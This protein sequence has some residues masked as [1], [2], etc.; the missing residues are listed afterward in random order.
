MVPL[1]SFKITLGLNAALKCICLK[2]TCP[3]PGSA[4]VPMSHSSHGGGWLIASDRPMFSTSEPIQDGAVI[5]RS[6][7]DLRD[8]AEM[9]PTETEGKK[10]QSVT[11]TVIQ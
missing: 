6:C 7:A 5:A 11:Y 4:Y 9:F 10:V 3:N 1:T 8:V 2:P